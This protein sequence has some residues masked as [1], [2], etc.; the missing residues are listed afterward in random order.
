MV[1]IS[2]LFSFVLYSADND[3]V[4]LV[5]GFLNSFDIGIITNFSYQI[6]KG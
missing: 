2:M 1:L 4:M 5:N 3:F 6:S